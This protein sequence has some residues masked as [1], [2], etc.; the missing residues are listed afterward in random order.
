M[1]IGDHP[2][3]CGKDRAVRPWTKA[4]LGSPPLVRE[5]LFT[6]F[7]VA[8]VFRITPARAGKTTHDISV[9]E[10]L[11]DHPRSCGKDRYNI[12]K[13]SPEG[14]SPPLVRER[15]NPK[16][17]PVDVAGITPARAGKT[18]AFRTIV[19]YTRDHPRSCGKDMQ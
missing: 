14:G 1:Y 7:L 19:V 9:P 12:F 11:W 13:M 15:L 16:F 4:R 3:S 18:N 17:V 2:R 6:P 10:F 8:L 5:R